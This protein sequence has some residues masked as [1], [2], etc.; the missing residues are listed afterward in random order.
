M[1]EKQ[2]NQLIA[3]AENV[4]A[5]RDFFK[6]LYTVAELYETAAKATVVIMHVIDKFPLCQD[7]KEDLKRLMNQHLLMVEH[8][9]PF[10]ED[11]KD[12][13]V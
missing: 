11:R 10:S 4:E 2:K 8:M 6:E 9:K 7:D 1:D 3:D 5:L 12:G 13:D